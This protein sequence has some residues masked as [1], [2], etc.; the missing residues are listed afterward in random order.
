MIGSI[1]PIMVAIVV[2]LL[3]NLLTK[4]KWRKSMKA[5]SYSIGK[6]GGALTEEHGCQKPLIIWCNR[7]PINMT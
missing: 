6:I 7:N 4:K 5:I 2:G 3:I 1:S